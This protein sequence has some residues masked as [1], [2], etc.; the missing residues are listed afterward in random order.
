M[1]GLTQ[2]LFHALQAAGLVDIAPASLQN[3][4][5]FLLGWWYFY[6]SYR[7]Q[8]KTK[9]LL[10]SYPSG[11]MVSLTVLQ[12][13]NLNVAFSV[14]FCFY[15]MVFYTDTSR[16]FSSP[17]W[18]GWVLLSENWRKE[19]SWGVWERSHSQDSHSSTKMSLL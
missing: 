9:Q 11:V 5:Y 6:S 18:D 2:T 13:S 8:N 7:L 19:P 3:R 10:L 16:T 4:E 12:L 1:A 17:E 15:W 14:C